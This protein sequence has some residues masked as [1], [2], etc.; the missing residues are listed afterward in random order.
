MDLQTKLNIILKK[1]YLDSELEFQRASIV[2]R[3]LRLLIETDLWLADRRKQ[4]RTILKA[5]EDKYWVNAE[6]S[7]Q[8]AAESDLAIQIAEQEI[9]GKQF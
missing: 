1:G 7:D 4:L 5:Y 8:Q 9:F 3:Q 2:E 6:I